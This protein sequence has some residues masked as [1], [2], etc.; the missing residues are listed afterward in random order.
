MIIR[1]PIDKKCSIYCVGTLELGQKKLQQSD[2]YLYLSDDDLHEQSRACA[3][4]CCSTTPS[5][6]RLCRD[7]RCDDISFLPPSS[8]TGSDTASLVRRTGWCCFIVRLR[9]L[10]LILFDVPPVRRS[11]L[12]TEYH[13]DDRG[14]VSSVLCSPVQCTDRRLAPSRHHQHSV[15]R[16]T[17]EKDTAQSACS[18]FLLTKTPKHIRFDIYRHWVRTARSWQHPDMSGQAGPEVTTLISLPQSQDER[19]LNKF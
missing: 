12:T 1:N 11:G 4:C 9:L 17:G 5:L 7:V 16:E 8:Y 15:S 3:C 14:T 2:T 6:A 18:L 19:R 10:V 13:R